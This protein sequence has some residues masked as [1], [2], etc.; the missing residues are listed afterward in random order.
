MIRLRS[1][2]PERY[3]REVLPLTAPL[4]AGARDF[5]TYAA[6]TQEI[7][8]SDYGK[9]NFRFTGLWEGGTLLSSC[10]QYRRTFHLDGAPLPAVG[11]GA[12]FTA[13][14]QRGRGYG[15]AMLGMVLDFAR[16]EGSDLV[17]LFSDIGPHFYRELGFAEFPSRVLSF[18][19]DALPPARIAV[20]T[21]EP[22]DWP[23][24]E[25]A[26]AATSADTAWGM[27]RPP[28]VWDWIRVR[29]THDSAHA[30]GQPIALVLRRGADACA[31]V[32][33]RRDVVRDAFVL[34][35]FGWLDGAA[36]AAIPPMLRNAAGD[37]R[38]ITGWVPPRTARA[39]LPRGS[40]RRRKDA[41]LMCAPLT[42][43]GRAL[44]AAANAPAGA[45]GVWV[46]DRI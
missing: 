7:A 43:R 45:D 34:E 23:G 14:E 3:A 27:L 20:E 15:S 33:G 35:E 37:L 17:Y 26:Y 10:K 9:E 12:V 13:P 38:R 29:T 41:L 21:L 4:W 5:S 46:W 16:A 11:I 8:A 40:V 44:V 42:P 30:R 6:Q 18:R 1:L 39:L 19:A 28:D 25:R 2:S 31:Y 36:R 22:R 24:I 32:A